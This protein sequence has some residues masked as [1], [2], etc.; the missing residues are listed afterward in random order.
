M[1]F[2]LQIMLRRD[3]GRIELKLEDLVEYELC[4]KR[5]K[6]EAEKD[7]NEIEMAKKAE[8]ESRTTVQNQKSCP[9]CKK[10]TSL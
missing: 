5:K 4:Q 7:A 1:T 6:S 2:L 10:R 9:K 3:L 8:E